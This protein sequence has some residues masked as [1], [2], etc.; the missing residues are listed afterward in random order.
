ML[1]GFCR[2]PAVP[3]GWLRGWP[4]LSGLALVVLAGLAANAFATG[5]LSH[6]HDRYEARIAWLLFMA[7]LLMLAAPR[8]RV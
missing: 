3:L 6:P 1:Y 5:A 4:A 7:P 2:Q 8:K